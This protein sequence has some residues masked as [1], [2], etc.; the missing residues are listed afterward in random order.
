MAIEKNIPFTLEVLPPA[1]LFCEISPVSLAVRRGNPAVFTVTL[2]S[3]NDLAGTVSLEV[4]GLAAP[5]TS[6]TLLAAGEEKSVIVSI[7]TDEV[8]V[9]VHALNLNVIAVEV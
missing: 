9:A 6:E 5:I 4:Q 2:R 7:P 8:D 1:D 3:L